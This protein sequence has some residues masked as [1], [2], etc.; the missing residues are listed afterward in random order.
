MNRF[1]LEL[2]KTKASQGVVK[3]TVNVA[4][5]TIAVIQSCADHD[6]DIDAVYRLTRDIPFTFKAQG[7]GSKALAVPMNTYTP[8][9]AQA[10]VHT[11][12]E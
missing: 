5:D 11:Y 12:G 3:E 6:P 1:P 4:M 10:T 9:N 8:Y 2:I 7:A